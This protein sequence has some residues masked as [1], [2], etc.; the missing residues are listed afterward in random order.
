[1]L[2]LMVGGAIPAAG[3]AQRPI[4][5][6]S[7]RYA[8]V[9]DSSARFQTEVVARLWF[10]Q[11]AQALQAGDTTLLS[12]HLARSQVPGE[13]RAA[14]ARAGC[15]SAGWAGSELR[16]LRGRSGAVPLGRLQIQVRALQAMPGGTVIVQAR[17]T[18]VVARP[19]QFAD[20]EIAFARE[21]VALVPASASGVVAALCGMALAR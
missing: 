15:P 18:D 5:A 19:S 1:M 6:D 21:G 20:F 11:L 16:R 12:L 14:A 3:S 9:L 4:T 17:L 10:A 13:E 7:S 2:A 8:V